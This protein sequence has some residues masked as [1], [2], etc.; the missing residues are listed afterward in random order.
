MLISLGLFYR[1]RKGCRWWRLEAACFFACVFEQRLTAC[2][3]VK[4]DKR[5]LQGM[6]AKNV[7]AKNNRSDSVGN[8][9]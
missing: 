5:L 2:N 6:L 3:V 7:T 9:K 4:P 1:W 8:A